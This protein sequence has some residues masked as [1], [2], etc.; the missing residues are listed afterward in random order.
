MDHRKS[1]FRQQFVGVYLAT[2]FLKR[3]AAQGQKLKCKSS[4][5]EC[6]SSRIIIMCISG[7]RIQR[8]FI[9]ASYTQKNANLS[10]FM[11]KKKQHY[12]NLGQQCLFIAMLNCRR[13]YKQL[14]IRNEFFWT[15]FKRC[16]NFCGA[17]K[18]M[19]Q[20]RSLTLKP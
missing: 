7:S 13:L 18:L 19:N 3:G 11:W 20:V 16:F 14:Y 9:S 8:P 6:P 17:C 4:R 10:L 15:C 12:L 2:I 1:F 5:R